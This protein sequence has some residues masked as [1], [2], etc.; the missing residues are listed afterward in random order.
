MFMHYTPP[1]DL[2]AAQ[3]DQ[4]PAMET[5]YILELAANTVPVPLVKEVIHMAL[6]VLRTCE[7]GQSFIFVAFHVINF[8][9]KQRK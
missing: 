1:F 5:L 6:T 8:I 9:R 3:N 2:G 7:V 4:A